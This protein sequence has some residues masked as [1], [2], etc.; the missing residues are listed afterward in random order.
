MLFSSHYKSPIGEIK[1]I[2]SERGIISVMFES[3]NSPLLW[4]GVGGEATFT[5]QHTDNCLQQ[6]QEYFSGNRKEFE[7]EFELQGT[8]FQKKVW[9]ELL[10]VPY[11][12]TVSYSYIAKAT[13]DIKAV[14]AVGNANGKNKIAII[15]PCHRVI[16]SNGSLTGYAGGMARKK[17]LLDLEQK[18]TAPE[19]FDRIEEQISYG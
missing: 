16:G 18:V 6:L 2:A 8:D 5:N 19:L 3:P 17:W 4:R 11:G 13:G 10:K 15:I 7:L 14:R 12:K 9:E 1:I